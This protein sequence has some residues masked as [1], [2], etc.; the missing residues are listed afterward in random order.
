MFPFDLFPIHQSDLAKG[1]VKNMA[2]LDLGKG[3]KHSWNRELQKLSCRMELKPIWPKQIDLCRMTSVWDRII[4]QH[5]RSSTHESSLYMPGD[6]CRK[7]GTVV[8][9]GSI[10]LSKKLNKPGTTYCI[11]YVAKYQTS[12]SIAH[13]GDMAIRHAC[14]G[15]T[16]ISGVIIVFFSSIPRVETVSQ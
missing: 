14:R 15:R 13:L 2:Y 6:V 4:W 9:S 7:K 1:S 8:L 12:S 10:L 5:C 16:F 3:C 11:T